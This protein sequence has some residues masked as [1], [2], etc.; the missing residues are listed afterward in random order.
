LKK[1][2]P[3]I[4]K[5]IFYTFVGLLVLCLLS[6]VLISIPAI[7][8]K[9][10]GRMVTSF[11]KEIKTEMSIGYVSISWTGI[12]SMEDVLVKDQAGDSLFFIKNVSG[13]IHNLSLKRNLITIGTLTLVDPLC[14]FKKSE[15][16]DF[17]YF[18]FTDY[19]AIPAGSVGGG[20]FLI[21]FN[22]L[23][24]INGSFRYK[25]DGYPPPTDRKFDES[26]FAFNK[27][28]AEFHDFQ[29]IQDSLNFKIKRLSCVEK[30]GL[31]L[32]QMASK[33]IIH[34]NGMKFDDLV[35]KTKHSHL[36]DYLEFSFQGYPALSDFINTVYVN[37]NLNKSL[38]S[39]KDL[40]YFSTTLEP[41][42]N[43]DINFTGVARGLIK[44]FK[45]KKFTASVGSNI[46]LA[47]SMDLAGMPDWKTSFV[48]LD[49]KQFETN[50]GALEDFLRIEIPS[51][52][53]KLGTIDFAGHLTGFYTDF[54]ADGKLN[55]NLGF[56]ESRINFKIP[57][58][59]EPTYTGQLKADNFAIGAFL[60]QPQLG[61]TSFSFNLKEGKGLRLDKFTSSFESVVDY[62]EFNGY[63]IKNILANG[64]YKN[65]SFDGLA[66]FK[67]PNINFDF[68][69]KMDF[70]QA[71]PVYNFKSTI[72]H[73]NLSMLGLDSMTT[74]VS[75]FVDVELRGNTLDNIAGNAKVNNFHLVRGT[76]T[77]DLDSFDASSGYDTN[78][79]YVR[80]TSD[81][82]DADV[83]GNF[84]FG[85]LK[86]VSEEF[87]HILFPDYYVVKNPLANPVVI[88]AKLRIRE[89]EFIGNL[90]QLDLKLGDGTFEATYDSDLKSL[91]VDG[92]MNRLDY[93]DITL[94]DYYLNI[95]KKP[96]Q[97]LN[98]STDVTQIFVRDSLLISKVLLNASI[99]PNDI[100]FLLNFADTTD[101][102]A[103]RSFGKLHFSKDT[104]E[105][106]LE[107]S[108]FFAG[109]Q[110]WEIDN[111][112]KY[113]FS[114]G[115][116][117]IH[118]L[119]AHHQNQNF[120]L[121]GRISKN[122]DERLEIN[123]NHLRLSTF[124]PF[125]KPSNLTINGIANGT[126]SIYQVLA[127][128]FIQGKFNIDS[129]QVN[130]Q[131][132]G[133]L[134]METSAKED[135]MLMSVSAYVKEGLLKDIQVKGE[136]DFRGNHEN[137][138]LD[139]EGKKASIKPL[140]FIFAGLASDFY[141]AA[142]VKLKVTGTTKKPKID[143][144]V[145]LFNGGFKVDYLQTKY[146]ISDVVK[147]SNKSIDFNK[148]KLLDEFGNSAVLNGKVEHD[149]FDDFV[150]NISL[151]DAKD[152][153]CLNTTS[154]DNSLFYGKGVI[155][156]RA[157]FMGPLDNIVIDIKAET[158]KGTQITIP[159]LTD[160]EN[161]LAD[162]I[163][164]KKV[165]DTLRL[166]KVKSIEGLTMNFDFKL[167]EDAEFILLFD[168]VLDDKIIG[169][170]NGSVR[171]TYNS[172]Q[173]FYMFGDFVI[174]EGMYP[175][176]SPMM[177]SE[178]FDLLE[179]GRI[180]WNG[181]PYNAIIDLKAAVN[182]SRVNPR[183]LMIGY[184]SQQDLENYNTYISMNVI[185]NLKGE[186]FSPNISF[187]IEFVENAQGNN[188]VQ[189]YNL[190]KK[191]ESDK[192]ELNR[193]VFSL[194]S[195]GSF[196]PT[197]SSSVTGGNVSGNTVSDIVGSSVG[198]FLS[199]QVNSW[200]S[201][202]ENIAEI[203]VDYTTR[204]G[205]TDQERQELIVSARKKLF[206]NRLELAGSVN[207]YSGTGGSNPYNLDV[208]YNVKKDGS[209]KLKAYHKRDN[210]TFGQGSNITTTG[211]G[212]YFRI[213]FNKFNLKRTKNQDQ[214][215]DQIPSPDPAE[216]VPGF[217]IE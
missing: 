169:R 174:A 118:R 90:M 211:V 138:N 40:A 119:F 67:D 106:Q 17:N 39:L 157:S 179:G 168:E 28:N 85:Y 65:G 48:D 110:R 7:Q 87:L 192:D 21:K 132:L 146:T 64:V 216:V 52:I 167:T 9:V 208:L 152:F 113:L 185:L 112:N 131:V 177:V 127:K 188:L 79:R 58:K 97:L 27:I 10:I 75:A 61:K 70:N 43:Y 38:I 74:A 135:P 5:F 47:G 11:E 34:Y 77:L 213:Q 1:Y 69:G 128:P 163:E 116:H 186:L 198:S 25:M 210:P 204:T 205:L 129:M 151:Y 136:L 170:G 184:V 197:L 71:L 12:I 161:Q 57:E 59:S 139:I 126:L 111:Q 98:M 72:R 100:D 16:N 63:P 193:Q 121:F 201:A 123:A 124:N 88:N 81:F 37:V 22:T 103:L 49:L 102:I 14:N 202:Y 83:A 96:F 191:I 108:K 24:L 2:I 30:N 62:L 178:K 160:T 53:H 207:T 33:A 92:R 51:N 91:S 31:E 107:E 209:L 172:F 36:E 115:E 175:F 20:V 95:R 66:S 105:L 44:K 150:L 165:G 153:M 143:G 55:S 140:E 183:D 26:D 176:S 148:I 19:F 76:Y 101:A 6:S 32:T 195:F 4:G 13:R 99:L 189:F 56:L 162:F 187:S 142:D 156:G 46:L 82:M 141:G 78:G 114:N 215:D 203:G 166:E 23:K 15:G 158:K 86:R 155:S 45:V 18:F 89:N 133:N 145:R 41:Y 93:K 171:M 130:D 80:F 84:N 181:D 217:K 190:L 42:S 117:I 206:D 154:D 164:F 35:F 60:N 109:G 104:I 94:S 159:L 54:A 68:D 147:I 180:I 120:E 137:I 182:R 149:F 144:T 173:D 8:K 3:K 214:P 200:L 212:F 134:K 194:L 122:K 199:N 29:L 50:I 125:L 196:T 73:I